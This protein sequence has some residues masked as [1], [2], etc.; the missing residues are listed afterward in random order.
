[1]RSFGNISLFFILLLLQAVV[2]GLIGTSKD[3]SGFRL[4]RA[5]IALS[6]P[7]KLSAHVG[8]NN[9]H[10]DHSPPKSM[11]TSSS[12]SQNNGSIS[13]TGNGSNYVPTATGDDAFSKA[14]SKDKI[15]A[16]N[17]IIEGAHNIYDDKED[18][19]GAYYSKL[20]TI[21]DDEADPPSE[22][23]TIVD[24]QTILDSTFVNDAYTNQ[25]P[26]LLA[27]RSYA[28]SA[29]FANENLTVPIDLEDLLPETRKIED[30]FYFSLPAGLLTFGLTFFAFPH[31]TDFIVNY[32]DSNPKDLDEI[33]SKLVPGI[34]IMYGTYI[35]LTLNILYN[36]QRFVQDS[37]AQETSMLSFCLQNMV[38]LFRRDRDRMVRSGQ[39][40]ADQVQIL[41]KETRGQEYMTV[42][43]ADPYTKLLHLVEEEEE[44]LVRE[45]GDFLS[46]GVSI[47]F[48]C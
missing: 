33:V 9:K 24:M 35:S 2:H 23:K 48:V 36:R 31:V 32:M 30:T 15:E 39:A 4:Q 40:A 19:G 29:P 47:P 3:N 22:K 10:D 7:S 6:S 20:P 37:V 38:S 21:D 16:K 25:V 28:R 1:M 26:Y 12:A 27:R 42:V 5:A 44:R 46:K 14:K 8:R 17:M 43:Y 34:T 41:L 18:A 11:T 45:H 13:A